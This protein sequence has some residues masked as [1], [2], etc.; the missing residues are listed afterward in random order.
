MEIPDEL[1]ILADYRRNSISQS[2]KNILWEIIANRRHN[3]DKSTA[4]FAFMYFY[5]YFILGT[6]HF[7]DRESIEK[8]H[9]PF[10]FNQ[11]QGEASA[12][13]RSRGYGAKLKPFYIGGNYCNLFRMNDGPFTT[14]L[15]EWAMKD[16][17]NMNQLGRV[18]DNKESFER[19]HFR[20]RYF[21][22][23]LKKANGR[24]TEIPFFC[25]EEFQKS[26]LMDFIKEHNFK[27]FYVYTDYNPRVTLELPSALTDLAKLYEGHDV[28]IYSS[29]NYKPPKLATFPYG[30]G[31]L[32]HHLSE[33]LTFDWKMGEKV[34]LN[35]EEGVRHYYSS[36]F[37]LA[38]MGDPKKNIFYGRND[39]NG[40]SG[41]KFS[42]RFASLKPKMDWKPQIRVTVAITNPEYNAKKDERDKCQ[43]LIYIRIENELIACIDAESKI[44]SKM[45]HLKEPSRIRVIVDILEESIKTHPESGLMIQG[46][47]SLS[48]IASGKALH[49]MIYDSLDLAQKHMN[50][51]TDLNNH[52]QFIH[53]DRMKEMEGHINKNL[54]AASRSIKRKKEGLIFEDAVGKYLENNL[55]V[56]DVNGEELRST[57]EHNDATIAARHDLVGQ[58][59]DTLGHIRFPAFSVWLAVQSK[60]R[61]SGIP[62]HEVQAFLNSVKSLRDNKC[63]LNP[64]DKVISVLSLAKAKSFNYELYYT[65]LQHKTLPV[66][67]NSMNEETIGE[68]TEK[69]ILSQLEQIV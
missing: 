21:E 62:A 56:M 17:I 47:K 24:S 63:K 35:G 46:I 11:L 44:A 48:Q 52:D 20:G 19:E 18:I 43:E 50:S 29:G 1:G 65:L 8:E 59:I 34:V 69:A 60:D 22:P 25:E 28:E 41:R 2:L 61:E 64:K 53:A 58:A 23:L 7:R 55:T 3:P 36:E 31:I 40:S 14:D 15:N 68:A 26:P 27:C 9:T 51:V 13:I 66:I 16:W 32:P 42:R 67:E 6:N 57:W 54:K 12:A 5:P 38:F 45:R 30:Y 33:A 49:E 39:S 4:K 37:K 10:K